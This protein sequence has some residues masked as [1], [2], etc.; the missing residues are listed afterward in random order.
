M[1][2]LNL[3]TTHTEDLPVLESELLIQPELIQPQ[4]DL[5]IQ[6]TTHTETE[7]N[8]CFKKIYIKFMLPIVQFIKNDDA[9][10]Y[11]VNNIKRLDI[12][13]AR[14]IV[15]TIAVIALYYTYNYNVF[16][17]TTYC[18]YYYLE[19]S[20]WS[21]ICSIFN[22]P[23][24]IFSIIFSIIKTLIKKVYFFYNDLVKD[25]LFKCAVIFSLIGLYCVI[26]TNYWVENFL[27]K[28][29]ICDYYTSKYYTYDIINKVYQND[30]YKQFRDDYITEGDL[31]IYNFLN[32][33]IPFI[34]LTFKCI[35]MLHYLEYL[36]I[37]TSFIK[38]TITF[39]NVLSTIKFLYTSIG[40]VLYPY[41]YMQAKDYKSLK[42]KYDRLEQLLQF[43]DKKYHE[44]IDSL[45]TIIRKITKLHNKE[46][47]V[48]IIDYALKNMDINTRKKILVAICEEIN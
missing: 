46:E 35:L 24:S 10:I 44:D 31:L 27:S 11:A 36:P 7:N 13:T 1:D 34:K 16:A 32:F 29:C 15:T 19:I 38:K 17:V 2:E 22:N 20:T 28:Y 5:L 47:I 6:S 14:D 8:S 40:M 12:S 4:L 9:V 18:Y 26:K 37:I 21:I 30:N 3:L 39:K 23:L 42:I 33:Y 43:K 45:R 41:Q 25:K 48:K